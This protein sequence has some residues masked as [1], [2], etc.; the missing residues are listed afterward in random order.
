MV[1]VL[2]REQVSRCAQED[3]VLRTWD[4]NVA[5]E[6]RC[7]QEARGRF[8]LCTHDCGQDHQGQE[9]NLYPQEVAAGVDDGCGG[10]VGGS[11]GQQRTHR[12]TERAAWKTARRTS[13]VTHSSVE[14]R[15]FSP[16]SHS[17]LPW[18]SLWVG[19]VAL[20]SLER[21]R[22][23]QLPP[24]ARGGGGL[25][26]DRRAHLRILASH[27]NF[28]DRADDAVSRKEPK[29]RKI[30]GQWASWTWAASMRSS[31]TGRRRS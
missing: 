13:S 23:F 18:I 17:P 12:H 16:A 27:L 1:L 2:P 19:V 31:S 9:H 4:S 7:V 26:R 25:P 28:R 8:F 30:P 6:R 11:V 21:L 24:S 29:S 10:G 5:L 22:K 20:P 3:D 15:A 14:D